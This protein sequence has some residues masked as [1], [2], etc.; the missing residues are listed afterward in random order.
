MYLYRREHLSNYSWGAD[1]D[2]EKAAFQ[3]IV[4]ALGIEPCEHSPMLN[5]EVCVAY[6]RKANA[7]HG[8][9]VREHGGGVD[10]CQSIYLTR[11]DL[12]V[13]RDKCDEILC[14]PAN[15][16]PNVAEKCGLNTVGGFF[17]GSTDYDEWYTDDL[18]RTV[19]Q[20][21][22]ILESTSEDSWTDFIYRASW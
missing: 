20:I 12:K 14:V 8:Y 5:V 6:W 18:K 15:F 22:K 21:D 13:L 16:M 19:N 10:E 2:K 9:I 4:D 11:N 7:I 1:N 3:T 17:F